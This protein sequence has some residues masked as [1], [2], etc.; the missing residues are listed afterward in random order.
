MT[1]GSD[2]VSA[3]NT[4]LPHLIP[5]AHRMGVTAVELA[6]GVAVCR[7]PPADNGNHLGTM[8]A[9]VLSTVAEVLGGA[10]CLPSFDLARFHPVVRD[11]R[12]DFRRPARTDVTATA[13]LDA[14]TVER[15]RAKADGRSTF[16]LT[17]ELTDT[18]GVV[19]ATTE[20]TYQLR[21][22]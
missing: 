2:L 6:P 8:Y 16:V 18:G 21:R 12:I 7:V 15:V 19:I 11:L 20:G 5:Q 17:T 10:I 9:G 3:F 22:N 14:A 4:G 1:P 13:A